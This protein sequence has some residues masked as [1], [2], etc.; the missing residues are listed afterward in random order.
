MPGGLGTPDA[1]RRP[2][3]RSRRST[4]V[5]EPRRDRIPDEPAGER[6]PARNIT[7]IILVAAGVV[8]LAAILTYALTR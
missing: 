3:Q 7:T 1:P 2:K 4:R 8:V 5:S 6:A